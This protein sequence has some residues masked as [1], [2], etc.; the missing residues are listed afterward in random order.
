M[1]LKTINTV[2]LIP[3][4][5]RETIDAFKV[6][7]GV[8]RIEFHHYRSSGVSIFPYRQGLQVELRKGREGL[9]P[10]CYV[11]GGLETKCKGQGE[12]FTCIQIPF[13]TKS[14]VVVARGREVG[15][16]GGE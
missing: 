7:N 14:L 10:M 5:N 6:K 2:S 11:K 9:K 13:Y 8:I 3:L 15:G 16:G 1:G 12:T 4:L